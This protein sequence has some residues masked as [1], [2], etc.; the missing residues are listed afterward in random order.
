MAVALLA[1]S[2]V[3]RLWLAASLGLQKDEA[4]YA[5]WSR[6][7]HLSYAF[8]PLSAMRASCA[9]FGETPFAA[10]LPFVLAMTAAGAF[11][12][13]LARRL[14][15]SAA[16]GAWTVA[17]LLGNVW[18]HFAGAQ[19]HPDAFLAM[20]WIGA[21]AVL[22]SE[23]VGRGRLLAGA[24]L[25]AG[26][27]LSKYT[28]YLL[29]PAWVAVELA[30]GRAGGGGGS[31]GGNGGNGGGE[32]R[33]RLRDLALATIL[34][35]ALVSPGLL[36]M[37]AEQGH[38][39]RVALHLSDLRD[40][41]SLPA[42]LA[43]L[44]LAPLLFPL[45]PGSVMF[46]LAPI[47]AW[48]AGGGARRQVWIGIVVFAVFA[49]LAARGS[50]KGNWLLPA[51]WGTLPLGAAWFLR[52]TLRRRWLAALTA[53]GIALAAAA[54]VAVLYP[55]R[56]AALAR[57]GPAAA[58]DSSY[59]RSVSAEERRH[60]TSRRW[61]DRAYEGRLSA[62]LADSL[63]R[64]VV[65]GGPGTA[66]V[67]DQ[68]EAVYAVR[69]HLPSAPVRLLGDARFRLE[70]EYALGPEEL[71]ERI[72]YVTAPGTNLPESFFTW[73]GYLERDRALSV[74]LGR[75]SERRYDVWR[76]GRSAAGW[77]EAR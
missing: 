1:A 18:A 74:P 24:A 49:A 19:A 5:V 65:A 16:A 41:L 20:F 58:L 23:P 52:G 40:Q 61:I 68:Y 76:C 25:A 70:P 60:A 38:W 26:A 64:R 37:V 31:G 63:A 54:H 32:N 4:F 35:L 22:A 67:S 53:A 11:A 28:G 72:L 14:T 15:G 48:R 55:D 75:E 46:A 57:R 62:P 33:A 47:A 34:W 71:P 7:L 69:F 51:F 36:A 27:A 77:V 21:L 39:L 30:R 10:R 45:S 44:P 42:R 17:L 29:W 66:I 43:L 6:G 50:L 3:A 59:A 12:Y 9:V 2:L 8:L 56:L 73:Y 13:L